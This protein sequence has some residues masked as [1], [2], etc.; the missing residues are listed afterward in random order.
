MRLVSLNVGQPRTVERDGRSVLTAHYREPVSGRLRLHLLGLDTDAVADPRHHGG[1][2]KAVYAY[3][4]EHAAFWAESLGREPGPGYF[5]ENFTLAGLTEDRVRLGA[6]YRIGTAVVEV[7]QPRNPCSKLAFRVGR[8]DFLREFTQSLRCGFY[9]RVL[10]EGE[11]GAGDAVECL[12][13][14]EGAP[15][16]RDLFR[17]T[18]VERPSAVP[19][20][21]R[22][23]DAWRALMARRLGPT[24]S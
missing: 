10:E 11:V 17:L 13:P 5:G 20:L 21:P 9:L 14:A 18:L 23:A 12:D 16:V 7:S 8:P 1:P 3:P 2:D 6:R 19:D 24:G 15:T 22:L 4:G